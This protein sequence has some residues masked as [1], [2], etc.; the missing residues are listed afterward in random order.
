MQIHQ[1]ILGLVP[2]HEPLP[3][4]LGCLAP[5]YHA[6]IQAKARYWVYPDSVSESS[7]LVDTLNSSQKRDNIIQFKT[8]DRCTLPFRTLD[9][10]LRSDFPHRG[11]DVALEQNRTKDTIYLESRVKVT[12]CL[13][14]GF[15]DFQ[16]GDIQ[17]LCT[18]QIDGG[19]LVFRCLRSTIII[20]ECN[21]RATVLLHLRAMAASQYSGFQAISCTSPSRFEMLLNCH[22][23]DS[24]GPTNLEYGDAGFHYPYYSEVWRK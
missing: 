17:V 7:P 2:D 16:S 5:G 12:I 13:R 18:Q 8:Y 6:A 9:P 3:S 22:P 11:E 15:F 14:E 24:M 10:C 4:L 23:V 21:V 1:A 20:F 19:L